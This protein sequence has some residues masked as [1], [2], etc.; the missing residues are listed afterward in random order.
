MEELT[1][2]IPQRVANDI[3]EALVESRSPLIR[4][5]DDIEKMKRD[6]KAGTKSRIDYAI[7]LLGQYVRPDN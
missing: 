3:Y 2:A 5:S 1:L 6:A 7:G 4:Y